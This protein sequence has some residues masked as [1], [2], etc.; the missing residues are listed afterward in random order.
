MGNDGRIGIYVDAVNVTL[1]GGYGL[2]YDVLRKF[3]SRCGGVSARLNAYLSYDDDRLQTEHE[4]R[5]KTL[6]F[7]DMLRD[8]EFKVTDK[9]LHT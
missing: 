2:R 4:Y 3:A 5:Q 9:P 6:R 8:F 1:N 7:C